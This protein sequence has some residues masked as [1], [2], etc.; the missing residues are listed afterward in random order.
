MKSLP[1]LSLAAVILL[2]SAAARP[3]VAQDTGPD[4]LS[5][6]PVS[7]AELVRAQ[8]RMWATAVPLQVRGTVVRADSLRL[9]AEPMD[10]GAPVVAPLTSLQRVQ[11]FEGKGDATTAAMLGGIVGAIAGY[12][13]VYYGVES[14]GD[15]MRSPGALVYGSVPGAVVGALIGALSAEERWRDV[16]ILP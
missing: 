3:V 16:R 15:D 4:T 6:A 7:P 5:G 2:S 1:A 10:G 13:V 11:V 14:S 12:L 9:V 8:V